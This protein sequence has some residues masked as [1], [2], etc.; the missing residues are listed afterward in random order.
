MVDAKFWEMTEMIEIWRKNLDKGDKT[1]VKQRYFSK[2][3]DTINHSLLLAKLDA[4]VLLEH[5]ENMRKTTYAPH[6]KGVL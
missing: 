3:F 5:P 4:Y 1:V 6:T 2:N